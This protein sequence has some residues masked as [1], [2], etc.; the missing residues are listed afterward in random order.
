MS[1]GLVAGYEVEN[2][3]SRN[4]RNLVCPRCTVKTMALHPRRTSTIVLAAT[5]QHTSSG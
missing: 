5:S 1:G 2:K 4:C 3:L